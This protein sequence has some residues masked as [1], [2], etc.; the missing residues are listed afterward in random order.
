[1]K[2][3]LGNEISRTESKQTLGDRKSRLRLQILSEKASRARAQL[4]L[5]ALEENLL[6]LSIFVRA[7][8]KINLDRNLSKSYRRR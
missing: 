3:N 6:Q 4:K 1:M 7:E 8:L 2:A 5:E